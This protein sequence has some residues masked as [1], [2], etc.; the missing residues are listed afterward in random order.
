[1]TKQ[2][3]L[4]HVAIVCDGNR[5]W[6][7]EKG[8]NPWDGHRYA[9]EKT[10]SQIIDKALELKIPYITFWVF[11]TENWDRP[12][13]EIKYLMQL[14]RQLFSKSK[15]FMEKN[16]KVKHIGYLP[17]FNKFIQQNIIKLINLT[18]KNSALTVTFAANYGGRDEIVRA[19]KKM[20]KGGFDIKKLTE[21]N[22]HK[23]LDTNG[24]PS[25][26]LIIRTSGEQR[27]SGFLLWQ[28]QY[29][30]FYFPKVNFPDF[31]GNELEKAV[32][33]FQNRQRRFGK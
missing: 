27:L 5:R 2:R 28:S 21:K 16:V 6:A 10:L 17:K 31:N 13:A 24:T 15:E 33:E 23:F 8:M 29:S 26:E 32:L 3:N 9:I 12:K 1:M 20:Y 25:P 11:S 19:I 18:K 22:F 4:Q 30:E 14:F 7:K